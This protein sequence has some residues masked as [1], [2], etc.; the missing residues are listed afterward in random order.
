MTTKRCSQC[1]KVKPVSEFGA[2]KNSSDG[3][4]FYCK[5]CSSV[6]NKSSQVIRSLR[7]WTER[8]DNICARCG[9]MDSLDHLWLEGEMIPVTICPT[10]YDLYNDLNMT[11]EEFYGWIREKQC[12]K[13]GYK[14]NAQQPRP[15]LCP[16]C[17]SPY[18]QGEE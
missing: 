10:C 3:L 6:R 12:V 4:S 11:I 7:K 18:W 5:S 17:K 15:A 1:E 16:R 8:F 2:N 13:C 9:R 14:W